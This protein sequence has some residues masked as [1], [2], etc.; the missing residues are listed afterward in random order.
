LG[1][2]WIDEFKLEIKD[3]RGEWQT[4]VIKNPGFEEMINNNV[5]DWSANSEDYFI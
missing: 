3:S 2:L 4:S 5:K 1:K